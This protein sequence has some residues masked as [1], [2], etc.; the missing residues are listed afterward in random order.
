MSV[1]MYM[2]TYIYI[3][4]QPALRP[5]RPGRLRALKG[6]YSYSYFINNIIC[7]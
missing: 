7:I 4:R 3:Y 6:G 1:Y 5:P 2:Y